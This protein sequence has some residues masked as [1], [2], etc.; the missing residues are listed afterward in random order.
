MYEL[1]Q[2]DLPRHEG[3]TIAYRMANPRREDHISRDFAILGS[4]IAAVYGVDSRECK[5][6]RTRHT[7]I[8]ALALDESR[9]RNLS[10]EATDSMTNKVAD[11]LRKP[12]GVFSAVLLPTEPTPTG[13]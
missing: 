12:S 1:D 8:A 10:T 4:I 6:E 9:S 5:G 2:H 11:T 7:F 13:S 3:L